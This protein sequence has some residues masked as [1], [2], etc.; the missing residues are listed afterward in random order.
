VIKL[1][2]SFR[3]SIDDDL[4]QNLTSAFIIQYESEKVEEIS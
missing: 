4:S 1:S 2:A 3:N